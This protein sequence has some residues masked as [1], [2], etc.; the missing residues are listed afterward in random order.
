MKILEI[1]KFCYP[2]RGAEKHFLDV[3]RL[4]ESQGHQV[5]FFSMH[6]E[7]NIDTPWKEYFVSKVGYTGEYT[8]FEKIKGALRMFHSFEAKR[9]INALLDDF[10]P[11]VVH[12]HNVYH[13]LSP[14]ILFEIKK[15]GIPIVMTVH[16]FKIV[17]PNHSLYLDGKFYDRCKGGKYY[18]CFLDKCVKDSYV[19]SLLATLETYWHEM[20]GTYRK[21][22][23]VFIA[24]SVF[25]RNILVERGI[26]EGKVTVLP[27]F[28]SGETGPTLL[29]ESAQKPYALY[30]GAVSNNKGIGDLLDIFKGM[31][32][33]R[34]LVAGAVEDE[35]ELD[36]IDNVEYLGFL[37]RSQL[38]SFMEKA[39]CVVS[40]SRLPETFGLIATEASSFGKPF[41][42]FAAGAFGEIIEN[43]K[44]GF[45]S[46]D[47]EGL[48][49]TLT[50]FSKGE[51]C[52]D[53]EKIR[54]EAQEKFNAGA[55][56]EK[57]GKI[58]SELSLS[59]KRKTVFQEKF[60]VSGSD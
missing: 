24:P 11:D 31:K 28:I 3:A 45:L 16:D 55:Y 1:N 35:T 54:K 46:H 56:A 42:G 41:F 44:N 50:A 49:E 25:V 8:L 19:K 38:D 15:R 51:M 27:H 29:R 58:F 60:Q 5:A 9:K 36:G 40:G 37:N 12:V 17:S 4:L 10:R 6:H 47:A 22:V 32:G 39:S 34:L 48:R 23:D 52:F 7:K 20:L 43:G 53:A 2:K 30:V 33:L 13:Q 21:N 57:I 26:D 14:A 59:G 18:R